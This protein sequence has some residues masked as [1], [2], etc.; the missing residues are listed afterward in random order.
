MGTRLG[1][2]VLADAGL[3]TDGELPA[4][5]E[6]FA[7][8]AMPATGEPPQ[9]DIATAIAAAPS[10]AA[11]NASLPFIQD[12]FSTRESFRLATFPTR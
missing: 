11:S 12:A 10:G 8:S 2:T 5:G 3:L 9:A 7:A 6:L 1:E 4:S